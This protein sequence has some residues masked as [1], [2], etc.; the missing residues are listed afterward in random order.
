MS[1]EL[2]DLLVLFANN[3]LPIFLAA[4]A[5]YLLSRFTQINPRTL[6][7]VIFYIFS[8]CLIFTLLTQSK[9]N[10][11]DIAKMVLLT[12]SMILMV[13]ALAWLGSWLLK[14]PRREMAGVMIASMFMNAG[15]YGL[16]VVL[17]A[18]GDTALSYASLFFVT[19]ATL[20]YTLGVVVISMGST[21]LAQAVSGLF[22]IPTVYALVLA[23]VLMQTGWQ[24][25]LFLERTTTLLG[26]A[27]IPCMLV[28]LGMQLRTAS[29]AGKEKPVLLA[30]AMRLLAGPA[31]L[32]LIAPLFQIPNAARQASIL[33]AGMPSAVLTTMLATEYD[34]EPALVTTVVFVSTLLSP[35]TLTPLLAFLGA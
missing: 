32:L 28:L 18:F 10:Q 33:E 2:Y 29:W 6:S 34:V 16:P 20:A 21:S 5:G 12:G 15:N 27:S 11:S 1:G 35:L 13:G 22:K 25:P 31:L 26:N 7:Q 8:P 19:S 9:L 24:M 3:L 4:G 30:T 23:M 17:F 14:L